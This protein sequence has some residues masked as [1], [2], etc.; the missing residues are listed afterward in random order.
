MKRTP[1]KKKLFP[2]LCLCTTVS[3]TLSTP[4][5]V[6]ATQAISD[7][8]NTGIAANGSLLAPGQPDPHY[9]FVSGPQSP[10]GPQALVETSISAWSSNGPHS[11]WIGV[12]SNPATIGTYV[13]R[14]SFTLPDNAVLNSAVITFKA[15]CDNDLTEV[16]LNGHPTGLSLSSSYTP[17]G[18]FTI[19]KSNGA[20]Q[21]GTNSLTF[22]LSNLDNGGPNPCG[23]RIDGIQGTYTTT[24]PEPK[25]AGLLAVAGCVILFHR[26]LRRRG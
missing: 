1:T 15:G 6:R 14:T 24:V 8:F 10:G 4:A 13:F 26:R 3:A 16:D 23:M 9:A 7:L 5:H 22:Y 12:T 25:S 18:T 19:D 2:L 21:T 20:F 17:A 11:D